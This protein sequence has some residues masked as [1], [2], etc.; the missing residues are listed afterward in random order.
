[1]LGIQLQLG[2]GFKGM[3]SLMLSQNGE[4]CALL[5]GINML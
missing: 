3:L 5:D 4:G 2:P 1:M